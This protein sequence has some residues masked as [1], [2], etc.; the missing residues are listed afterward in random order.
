MSYDQTSNR[1]SLARMADSWRWQKASI[2]QV[3]IHA[4]DNVANTAAVGQALRRQIGAS[5]WYHPNRVHMWPLD[6]LVKVTETYQNQYLLLVEIA[7]KRKNE[8]Q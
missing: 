6:T 1:L 7:R 2:R 3:E 4:R 5:M 8:I